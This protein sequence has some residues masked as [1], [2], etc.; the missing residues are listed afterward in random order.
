MDAVDHTIFPAL[1]DHVMAGSGI[2]YDLKELVLRIS[3]PHI[4]RFIGYYPG[5]KKTKIFCKGAYHS[6][7]LSGLNI[8]TTAGNSLRSL[9]YVDAIMHFAR[10]HKDYYRTAVLGDDVVVFLSRSKEAVFSQSFWMFYSQSPGIHGIGQ[11]AKKLIRTESTIDFLSKAAF[12]TYEGR[13]ILH[14][15]FY[16]TLAGSRISDK[17]GKTITKQAFLNGISQELDTW[18][19]G[20]PIIDTYATWMRQ[21]RKGTKVYY[22]SWHGEGYYENDLRLQQ[23]HMNANLNPQAAY[24]RFAP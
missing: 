4:K 18:S 15:D 1:Y 13:V 2:S 17:I 5:S 10:I 19:K 9:A 14:R 16:R 7:V 6:R 22:D 8:N 24:A 3:D 23:H 11:M 12:V 20:V 21:Q